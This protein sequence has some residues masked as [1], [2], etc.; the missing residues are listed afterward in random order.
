MPF[1]VGVFSMFNSTTGGGSEPKEASEIL[2]DGEFH[3]IAI[4]VF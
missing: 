4:F 3:E 1:L 2:C